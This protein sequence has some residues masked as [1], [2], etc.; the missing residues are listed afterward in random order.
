MAQTMTSAGSRVNRRFLFLGLILAALA[1][2]LVYA[3]MSRSDKSGSAAGD[4]PVVVASSSI[5]PGT[6]ITSDMV[7]VRELPESLV[8]FQALGELEDV[9]GQ[10]ARYPITEGEQV[11]LSKIVDTTVASNDAISYVVEPNM[12][13]MAISVEEVVNVGGLVLPGDHVDV[14]WVPTRGGPAFILLSDIEVTAVSQTIVDVAPAAPGLV[15]EGAE[16]APAEE[17]E[18]TRT[19]DAD[20]N[21][22]A[23]TATLLLTPEQTTTL[24]C[25]D[26]FSDRFEGQIRLAVRS[27]GDHAPLT[28]NAPTCPPLDLILSLDLG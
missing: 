19:S 1:A 11:L 27:F 7:D 14:L 22:E 2:V 15:D 17:G 6:R 3:A 13:G 20:A 18:R 21:P 26:Q 5:P 12:R 24:F 4:V 16:A 25:A 10:V 28:P 9:I 8:G 23:I